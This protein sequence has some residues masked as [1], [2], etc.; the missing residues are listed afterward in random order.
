[1][2]VVTTRDVNAPLVQPGYRAGLLDVFRRR[3]LLRL[4]VRKGIQQR[5]SGSFLGLLWSYVQPAVQFSVYF[6]VMGLILGMHKNVPNFPIHLFS[7]MVIVHYFTETFS[8]GTRSIVQNRQIVQ[9]MSLPRE[10]F[11]VS[12]M[13]VSAIH[14]FPQLLILWA[15]ALITGWTP[16]PVGLLAGFLGIMIVAVFGTGLALIFSAG[17]VFFRDFQNIVSTFALFIRWTVP[18]I[19]PF[20]RL[21]TSSLAGTWVYKVYLMNPISIAVLNV[22]RCF[23]SSTVKDVPNFNPDGFPSFPSHLILRGIIMLAV[24]VVFLGIC[25]LVF[26]R[27][28]GKLAERL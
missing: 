21:A 9:K 10:M 16:D 20:S 4:L 18:M 2:T 23:W 11:P 7:G 8:Q 12:A 6:F 13:M 24:A 5:Y 1:M 19:Y 25:Q 14:T 27:F 22:Q 15:G 28:E 17:N 26:S 3:Y